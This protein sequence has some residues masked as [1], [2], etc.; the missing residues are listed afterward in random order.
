MT[1]FG[2]DFCNAVVPTCLTLHASN[3]GSGDP[4][5]AEQEE[6]ALGFLRR[7]LVNW[8]RNGDDS[9]AVFDEAVR[10]LVVATIA[11]TERRRWR[12]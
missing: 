1:D 3:C 5:S 2:T 9:T 8:H 6:Q 10:M 12:R 7:K 11:E 4:C